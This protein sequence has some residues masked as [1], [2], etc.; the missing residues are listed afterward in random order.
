M[1]GG[2]WLGKAGLGMVWQ[3]RIQEVVWFINGKKGRDS[4]RM[5]K[6]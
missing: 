2:A 6:K 5:L 4:A 1:A 3:A